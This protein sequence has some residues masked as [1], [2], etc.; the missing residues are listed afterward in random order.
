[1]LKFSEGLKTVGSH[2][3]N[4]TE[5]TKLADGEPYAGGI[6]GTK[7]KWR[8]LTENMSLN[9]GSLINDTTNHFDETNVITVVYLTNMEQGLQSSSVQFGDVVMAP[10]RVWDDHTPCGWYTD[11]ELTKEWNFANPV[12]KDMTLYARWLPDE[13]DKN[14]EDTGICIEI[15]NED[16]FLYNGKAQRFFDKL[17]GAEKS[18][19]VFV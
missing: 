13:L 8:A 5:I 17:T 15:L 16:D 2:A 6:S 12:A 7:R 3:L 10:E 19:P 18:A 9:N 11:E 4:G 14:D 1:M